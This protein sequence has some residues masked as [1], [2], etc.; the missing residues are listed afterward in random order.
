MSEIQFLVAL[1]D[2]SEDFIEEAETVRFEKHVWKKTLFRVASVF[3]VIG[4]A[5]AL[6]FRV[7]WTGSGVN[8]LSVSAMELGIEEYTFG[9]A[10]PNVI[11][12]DDNI[13]IMYDFRGIYVYDLNMEKLTGFSDFRSIDMTTIQGDNPT[14]VEVSENGNYVKFYNENE[15]YLYDVKS[16]KTSHVEDYLKTDTSFVPYSTEIV[17]S[18]DANSLSDNYVTYKVK[19]D[20]FV[21]I[22]LEHDYVN[23]GKVVQYKDLRLTREKDGNQQEYVVFQ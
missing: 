15:K 8:P 6:F 18:G 5:A 20:A 2:L 16:N 13:I 3:L 22:S 23:A 1:S 9:V 19:G 12:G 14:L 10:L 11:Y 7:N 21:V 4:I 17:P